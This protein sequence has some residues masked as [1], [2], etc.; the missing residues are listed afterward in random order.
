ML[1]EPRIGVLWVGEEKRFREFAHQLTSPFQNYSASSISHAHTYLKRG[2]PIKVILFADIQHL[3]VL[4]KYFPIPIRILLVS[5][6]D[7]RTTES[8]INEGEIFRFLLLSSQ[9]KEVEEAIIDGARHYDLITQHQTLLS[10]LKN[11]NKKLKIWIE[12]LE[13]QV[14]MKTAKMVGIEFELKKK[15][16]YLEQ[17]NA[18]IAWIHAS[19]TFEELSMRVQE[20]LKGILPVEYILLLQTVNED[21]VKEVKKRGMPSL[22]MPLILKRKCLGHLYFL[23]KEENDIVQLYDRAD[24][25]KQI[26]D[27]VA[28]TLEKIRIFKI[29]VE[30]KEAWQ[31]TFDAIRDPVSL[32]N[33]QYQIIRANV[34]YSSISQEKI[35]EIV[36]KKCYEVFQK[37]NSPC[38][39]CLLQESLNKGKHENFELKSTIQDT[40]YMTS[41]FPLGPVSQGLAVLYYRDQGE[42]K[43]LKNQLIQAEKMA[44]VGILAGSVAHELNNPLGGI[45][46]YTQ[47]LL[48]EVP[49]GGTLYQDLKEIEAATHRSKNIV[50]NLLYFSKAPKEKDRKCVDII[51]VLEKAISL[52]Q[53]KIRYKNITIEKDCPESFPFVSGD[54]NQ[55]VQVFLNIFQDAVEAKAT[56]IHIFLNPKKEKKIFMIIE[57]NGIR[58]SKAQLS[59]LGLSVSLQIIK[60]HGGEIKIENAEKKTIF[61]VTMPQKSS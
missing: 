40:L 7:I 59:G 19:S 32:I 29:S 5:H 42:E 11:Q 55:L 10:G 30:R 20:S 33:K 58:I 27:T 39:G 57:D 8:A 3:Q 28:L 1:K 47:I 26:T 9:K 36:G 34:A 31:K 53:L 37:R 54:F 43:Q 44:E 56:R 51:K 50:E 12:K 24:L 49:K 22:V 46:A 48:S 38:E 60:N 6:L 41:A 2:I 23:C 14:K 21:I 13:D 61:T 45:L 25:L 15:K 52:I 18:L 35:Q 4:K 16:R 17:I